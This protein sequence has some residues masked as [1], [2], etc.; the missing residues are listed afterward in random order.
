MKLPSASEQQSVA[1][2]AWQVELRAVVAS[3]EEA[4]ARDALRVIQAKPS[5]SQV[6]L[7]ANPVRTGTPGVSGVSGVAGVSSAGAQESQG[8][9]GCQ[10]CL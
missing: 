7:D 1:F 9:L 10:G 3:P 2:R 4:E 8:Y 6:K 5:V